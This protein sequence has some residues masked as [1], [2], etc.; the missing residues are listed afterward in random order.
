MSRRLCV[1]FYRGVVEGKWVRPI[2]SLA[3][4]TKTWYVYGCCALS[5]LQLVDKIRAVAMGEY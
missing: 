5:V 4:I 1:S 3:V 2:F